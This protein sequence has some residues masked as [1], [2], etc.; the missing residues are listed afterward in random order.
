MNC[1]L[2]QEDYCA[3]F[4]KLRL[5]Y[6]FSKTELKETKNVIEVQ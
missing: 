4:Q 5:I 2:V 3:M 6:N 1:R